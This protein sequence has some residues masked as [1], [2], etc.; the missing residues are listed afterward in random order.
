MPPESVAVSSDGALISAVTSDG[1]LYVWNTVTGS[2]LGKIQQLTV[3]GNEPT[4]IKAAEFVR[5]D[6]ALLLDVEK[7]HC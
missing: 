4:K 5:D 6:T 1:Q 7:S 2:L 3:S